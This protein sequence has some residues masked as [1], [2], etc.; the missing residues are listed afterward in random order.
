MDQELVSIVI[1]T[2][3][4]ADLLP[5]ALNSVLAQ[6]HQNLDIIIVDDNAEFPE[7]REMV[8]RIVTETGDAR[9]SLIQNKKNL[10]GGPSRN[11]GIEASRGEYIAFL[12]DDDEYLPERIE[13]QLLCFKHSELP[14]LALVYVHTAAFQDHDNQIREYRNTCRGN[15]VYEGMKSCIAATS[16]WMCKKEALLKVGCFSDVPCKQDSNLIVKLLVHGYCI[17]YVPEILSRYYL[18]SMTSISRQGHNKRI[19]GEEALRELCRQHYD[20]I[21]E[22]QQ[23]EVEYTFACNLIHHYRALGMKEQYHEAKRILLRH[24]LRRKTL[25]LMKYMMLNR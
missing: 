21:T 7:T 6:T 18:D 4:R 19:T 14:D 3:K 15:C 12:D 11:A 20:L 1:P 2:Y 10:G 22:S 8:R 9:I 16:Q 25:G 5:R 17:D 24:P 23:K 13:K